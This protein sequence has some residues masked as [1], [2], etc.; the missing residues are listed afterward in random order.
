VGKYGRATQATDNSMI[1]HR[2]DVR[3]WTHS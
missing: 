2:K 3:I 1:Q